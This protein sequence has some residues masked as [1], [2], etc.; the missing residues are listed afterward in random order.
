MHDLDVIQGY[1]AV[2]QPS[3]ACVWLPA[4]HAGCE[5]GREGAGDAWGLCEGVRDRASAGGSSRGSRASRGEGS[6]SGPGVGD[7]WWQV[8]PYVLQVSR[9]AVWQRLAL[10]RHHAWPAAGTQAPASTHASC[11]LV[12]GMHKLQSC[13]VLERT[14]LCVLQIMYA[15]AWLCMHALLTWCS[16]MVCC[17]VVCRAALRW[18]MCCRGSTRAS[19]RQ[20]L[21]IGQISKHDRTVWRFRMANIGM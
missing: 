14:V 21:S 10:L 2:D 1:T 7:A 8:P 20:A 19:G 18:G 3:T 16:D 5:A 13:S 15:A 11:R 9:Q 12:H 17:N 6:S 4:G